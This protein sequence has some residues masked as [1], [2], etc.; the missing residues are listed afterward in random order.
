MIRRL[1]PGDEQLHIDLARRHKSTVPSPDQARAWLADERHVL[2][3]AIDDAGEAIGF[4]LGF[5]L[6]RWDGRRH[7]FL[8]EIE[9]DEPFRRAGRGRALVEEMLTIARDAGAFELWVEAELDD[10]DANAFYAGVGAARGVRA[11]TW[12]WRL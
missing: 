11:Q 9:V 4:A 5:V 3:A 1:R 8:Y 6:D 12:E 7:L 10:G 2:L